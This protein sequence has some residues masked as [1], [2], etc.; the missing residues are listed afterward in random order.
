MKNRLRKSFATAGECKH[1][2]KV[3]E[4]MRTLGVEPLDFS[5]NINPLGSPPLEELV[6]G[7]LKQIGHYPDSSY[8]GFCRAAARFVQ[9][10]PECIVPGNGSSELIRLFAEAVLE[11]GELALI[12]TPPLESMR[13]SHN[14]PEG[15]RKDWP[16]EQTAS[17]ALATPT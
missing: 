8:R 6:A 11:E 4:A 15:G 12:P 17:L 2:G 9:V 13:I 3:Q 1:G 14:S 7:E 10:D 5:A 16:S